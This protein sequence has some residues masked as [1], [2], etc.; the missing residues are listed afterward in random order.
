[1]RNETLLVGRAKSPAYVPDSRNTV[2]NPSGGVG[3]ETATPL[4]FL[5]IHRNLRHEPRQPNRLLVQELP[6]SNGLSVLHSN[7]ERRNVS[8]K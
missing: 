5:L 6:A 3:W 7:Q 2:G 4:R 1:M 8:I